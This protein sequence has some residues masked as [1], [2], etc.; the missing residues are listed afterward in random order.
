MDQLKREGAL[1]AAEM[2]T[3][4]GLLDAA[5]ALLDAGR[6]DAALAARLRSQAKPFAGS[7]AGTRKARLAG[8]LEGIAAKLG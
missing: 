2:A 6:T 8:V 1:G 3:L 4:S 7:G 5:E